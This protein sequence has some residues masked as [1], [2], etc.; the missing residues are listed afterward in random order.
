MAIVRW[1]PARELMTLRDQMDRLMDEFWGQPWP[2]RVGWDAG[3]AVSFPMD[4]YQTDK[5]YV[6]RATLPGV[7]AD[8][9][10]VSIVGE[11]LTI[12]A[13]AQEEQNVR[14]EDWLLKETRY[15]AYSRSVTLPSEVQAD[16]VD[17]SLE[18]GILKLR[19]PKAETVLPKT[20]KVK[21]AGK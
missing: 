12:K 11:T 10:D 9:L 20:I 21:T 5:E 8:D 18:N 4:I 1:S 3:S 17:A 19:I 13:T 7:R 16:K 15:V 2:R 14:D 6:V